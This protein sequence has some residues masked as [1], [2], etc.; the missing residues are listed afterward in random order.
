MKVN[1]AEKK[2]ERQLQFWAILGPFVLLLSLFILL[3]KVSDNQWYFA[4]SSVVGI[5]LCLKWKMRGLAGSLLFLFCMTLLSYQDIPLEE[6]YWHIGMSMALALSFVILTLSI[7]EVQGVLGELQNESQSRLEHLFKLDEK[8]KA[9]HQE[10]SLEKDKLLFQIKA[11]SQELAVAQEE[12]KTFEKLSHLAKEELLTFRGEHEKL[13]QD[14][15]EKKISANA[16]Q[17]R[18]DEMEETIQGFVNS[19]PERQMQTLVEQLAL[20]EQTLQKLTEQNNLLN[21][22]LES[23]G[24][25]REFL[26]AKLQEL[27]DKALDSQ[28]LALEK[29]VFYPRRRLWYQRC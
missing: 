4:L 2:V 27:E 6:R 24:Q 3:F 1:V 26:Q 23:L 16:L 21:K 8:L 22:Q 20:S 15:I 18:I 9:V 11:V 14:L 17:E 10:S 25:E 28:R 5:P 7:E 19:D 12:K 29:A 13:L